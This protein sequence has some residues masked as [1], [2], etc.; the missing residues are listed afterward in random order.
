MW[1]AESLSF[2][3]VS[4]SNQLQMFKCGKTQGWSFPGVTVLAGQ[5]F[6][7]GGSSGPLPYW[8]Y[9]FQIHLTWLWADLF[10][11]PWNI[12]QQQVPPQTKFMVL[13]LFAGFCLGTHKS[14][15]NTSV[16]FISSTQFGNLKFP[17]QWFSPLYFHSIFLVSLSCIVCLF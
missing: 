12:L 10:F 6:G 2:H 3:P 1:T 16:L 9:T 5:W 8:V 4:Y 15:Q 7:V 13:D 11:R 17:K 14:W